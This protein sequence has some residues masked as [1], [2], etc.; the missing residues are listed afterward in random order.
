M[1]LKHSTSWM[2]VLTVVTVALA[3]LYPTPEPTSNARGVEERD[4]RTD[5]A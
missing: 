2:P 4:L 5:T 1:R 3:A